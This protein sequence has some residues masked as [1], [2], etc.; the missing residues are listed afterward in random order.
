VKQKS[1]PKDP[2][3]DIWTY[4]AIGVDSKLMISW[5][6]GP[7]NHANTFVFMQDIALR[8]ATRVQLTKDGL[9]R[10]EAAVEQAFAWVGV[11]FAQIIRT[12]GTP[13]DK[14]EYHGRDSPSACRHDIRTPIVGDPD[15][16][17]EST[18]YLELQS[19]TCEWSCGASRCWRTESARGRRITRAQSACLPLLQVLLSAHDPD[20]RR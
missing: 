9:A 13:L 20:E 4:T 12:Y 11:D 1:A 3:S 7:R 17:Q 15:M 8:F 6:G 18:C 16:G 14:L 10:H 5:L 19:R 2:Q